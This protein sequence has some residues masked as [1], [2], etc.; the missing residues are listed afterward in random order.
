MEVT[1][2]KRMDSFQEGI[3]TV[4]N[5]KK[6]ELLAQGRTIYNLSVGTPDFKPAPHVMQALTESASK[7]ENYKY[8][9]VER[10]AL[11][12]AMQNF[13]N[14]RFGVQLDTKQIM[15]VN[16]S[17][18]AMTHICW[19][20]CDPG[21][22][23][24]VPNPGYPIFEVGPFLC[25]AEIVKYPLYEENGFLPKFSDIPEE[26][27]KKAK[28][29]V[30]SYPANPVC[31]TAND[32]FYEELIAF[33]KKYNIIIIHDNAYADIIYDGEGQSF[34]KYDG[35]S[36]VG[37]EYYSLSKTFD[38][39]G[40]RVSF[41]LGNEAIIQKFRTLRSQIDYGIFYPVQDAAIAA[42]NGPFDGVERQQEEY[43]ARNRALCGGLRSIGWNVPDSKGT[44][45]VWAPIPASYTSS[46]K[47]TLDL[48]E[49]SGV[50]VVPG[51]SFGSLGEGYVRMALVLDVP[52]MEKVVQVIKESGILE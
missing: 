7:P 45:F 21:D 17:Q 28:V 25:G 29:M 50:I 51:S 27:A 1:F 20:L 32:A 46:E 26:T 41:V 48:M 10:P 5:K 4:L 39:T 11:L 47:F 37:V 34:L 30:V 42:L 14:R 24:L 22:V 19:A 52:T 23:V 36:E 31:A 43:A 38:L 9:L 40:A 49:K 16:G 8:S 12:E 18:E 3:F 33:A 35:A 2:A 6:N 44:M 15:A 13:Y